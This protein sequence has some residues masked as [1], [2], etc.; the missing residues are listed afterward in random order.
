VGRQQL[1]LRREAVECCSTPPSILPPS[2]A[3]AFAAIAGACAF[4]P[5]PLSNRLILHEI[6]SPAHEWSKPPCGH[7]LVK[8]SGCPR[9]RMNRE[10]YSPAHAR[11]NSWQ[12]KGTGG[13]RARRSFGP[14][15]A[16]LVATEAE[17]NNPPLLFCIEGA[18]TIPT[19]DGWA[20]P[21]FPSAL[22]PPC[23]RESAGLLP[24]GRSVPLKA[25]FN[26]SPL[27]AP[28]RPA[29]IAWSPHAAALSEGWESAPSAPAWTPSAPR[30]SW[31][32]PRGLH[33]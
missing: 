1:G 26:P 12:T 33:P 28:E 3:C 16:E 27:P 15:A 24:T 5:P 20:G 6:C 25:S 31:A 21:F 32:A 29:I 11:S 10:A 19:R 14:A 23:L 9:R 8:T 30:L 13:G 2:T 17:R 22:S 18:L 7:R 4:N